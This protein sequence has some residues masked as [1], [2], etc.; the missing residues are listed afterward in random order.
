MAKNSKKVGLKGREG[1]LPRSIQVNVLP[2]VQYGV[3]LN[4]FR[5]ELNASATGM[6][7]LVMLAWCGDA[8]CTVKR[9]TVLVYGSGAGC[10]Y[11]AMQFLLVT[12]MKL[13]LV[14]RSGGVYRLSGRAV[15]AFGRVVVGGPDAALVEMSSKRGSRI[16]A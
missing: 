12:L 5:R 15:E 14:E 3:I 7:A 6:I 10:N 2:Y 9:L 13:G 1:G 11:R 16:M 8:G 4:A